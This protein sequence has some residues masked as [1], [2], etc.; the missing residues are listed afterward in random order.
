MGR[1]RLWKQRPV[2]QRRVASGRWLAL[3][4]GWVGQEW[5]E[6]IGRLHVGLCAERPVPSATPP[7]GGIGV[8]VESHATMR[9]V[10]A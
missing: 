1:L 10:P 3:A 2:G 9:H 5:T 7:G 6:P 4:D 8:R